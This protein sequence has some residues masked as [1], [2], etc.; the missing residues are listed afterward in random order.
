MYGDKDTSSSFEKDPISAKTLPCWDITSNLL[1][2]LQRKN[3]KES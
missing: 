1:R 3:A 2:V